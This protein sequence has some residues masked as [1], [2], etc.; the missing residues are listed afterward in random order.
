MTEASAQSVAETENTYLNLED[1]RRVAES[2]TPGTWNTHSCGDETCWC[3]M[4]KTDA[5]M[6]EDRGTG[7]V[8]SGSV[9]QND[10]QHIAAFNPKTAIALLDRIDELEILCAETYQV[11]GVLASEA[12]RLETCDA[13][14]KALDNLSAMKRVHTDVLPFKSGKEVAAR[15][16]HD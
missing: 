4:V 8:G 7:V 14:L 3:L 16:H 1:L 2:A 10:A 6:P 11:V 5:E 12:D 15:K 9:F 13:T